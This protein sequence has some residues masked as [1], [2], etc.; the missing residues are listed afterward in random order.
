MSMAAL[1]TRIARW[2]KQ[3]GHG[4]CK[5]GTVHSGAQDSCVWMQGPKVPKVEIDYLKL[6]E[7]CSRHLPAKAEHQT[8]PSTGIS[9]EKH[10]QFMAE[11]SKIF[12]RRRCRSVENTTKPPI[13]TCYSR[14]SHHGDIS[15]YMIAIHGREK[16][17]QDEIDLSTRLQ[18]MADIVR[19]LPIQ[20][21]NTE[22]KR[23]CQHLLHFSELFPAS[24]LPLSTIL[25]GLASRVYVEALPQR[26]Y[27]LPVHSG[28]YIIL[29]GSV[30][31]LSQD[32]TTMELS[33]LILRAGTSFGSLEGGN[34]DRTIKNNYPMYYNDQT[35]TL[36]RIAQVDYQRVLQKCTSEITSVN[37]RLLRSCPLLHGVSP[38][39]LSKLAQNVTWETASKR[40]TVILSEGERISR[41]GIIQEG[42]C[43]AQARV[44]D[45]LM[46]VEVIVGEVVPGDC[47]GEVFLRGRETQPFSIITGTPHTRIGWIETRAIKVSEVEKQ[48]LPSKDFSLPLLTKEVLRNMYADKLLEKQWR[49]IQRDIVKEVLTE[50][51]IRRGTSKW[52]HSESHPRL[53]RHQSQ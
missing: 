27:S 24:Q 9:R 12:K 25:P 5:E 20:R 15:S 10:D 22:V 4:G 46:S 32:P 35:C 17:E 23:L 45:T 28:V 52:L 41:V 37:E 2:K 47:I 7:L 6:R 29:Q 33:S 48:I 30:E 51:G 13:H 39:T 21:T 44:P 40:N 1:Y 31:K 26:G 42:R 43:T 14:C 38:S 53:S 11:Y 36:L 18:A 16:G 49:K 8:L 50:R 34:A 19:K 3:T